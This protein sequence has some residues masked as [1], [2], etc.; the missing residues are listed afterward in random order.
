MHL[1]PLEQLRVNGYMARDLPALDE[2]GALDPYLVASLGGMEGV[3]ATRFTGV[4]IPQ[5]QTLNA[6]AF[7]VSSLREPSP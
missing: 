2:N 6:T 4:P 1:A 5:T 3:G 7:P